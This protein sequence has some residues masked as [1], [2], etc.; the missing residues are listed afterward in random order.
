M[1]TDA[2]FWMESSGGYMR[3]VF[4]DNGT[5]NAGRI[6]KWR[7]FG[8][9]CGMYIVDTGIAPAPVSPFLILAALLAT[10][11]YSPGLGASQLGEP[12]YTAAVI[13]PFMQ[14]P[15]LVGFDQ[16][17]AAMFAPWLALPWSEP[18][19]SNHLAPARQFVIEVLE[20]NVG[21][22]V[23]F[24]QYVHLLTYIFI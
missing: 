7:A 5:T 21:S 19:P 4:L 11:K 14:L 17:I 24:L 1:T 18:I 22:F 15:V 23:L 3:P 8:A 10:A 6:D 12:E 2:A 20:K 9:L 16:D 13:N